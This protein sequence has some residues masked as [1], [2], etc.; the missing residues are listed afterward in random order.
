MAQRNCTTVN[1]VWRENPATFH[2]RN[3]FPPGG[4]VE[5]PATGAAAAALGAYLAVHDA[6]P[7]DRRFAIRQGEDMGRPSLL[8]VSVPLDLAEGI[9]VSGTAARLGQRESA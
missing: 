2:A 9:Q 4:V 5:D 1:L 8:S 6:L 3:P 7:P